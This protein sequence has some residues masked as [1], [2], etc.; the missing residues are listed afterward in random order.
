[1]SDFLY[2]SL[3]SDKGQRRQLVMA[4]IPSLF[5]EG[6]DDEPDIPVKIVLSFSER[7][8]NSFASGYGQLRQK[9]ELA[10]MGGERRLHDEKT[11]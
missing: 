6:M 7:C 3:A 2:I 9:L 4:N 10:F 5:S 8:K 1:M 11:F